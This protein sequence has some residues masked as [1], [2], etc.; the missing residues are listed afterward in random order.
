M[1]TSLQY[2]CI[3]KQTRW[4]QVRSVFKVR[5][6]QRS[7]RTRTSK[8]LCQ[9]V[10]QIPVGTTCL[11]LK[12][13]NLPQMHLVLLI[14]IHSLTPITYVTN[15]TFHTTKLEVGPV[16]YLTIHIMLRKNALSTSNIYPF[17][18]PKYLRDHVGGTVSQSQ[19]DRIIGKRLN[20]FMDSMDSAD[21]TD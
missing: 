19:P 7:P 18:H 5:G 1:L 6:L 2:K 13:A 15:V 21:W 11:R 4:V 3:N 20:R 12:I 17:S 10:L 9:L 14:Y 16:W 8:K